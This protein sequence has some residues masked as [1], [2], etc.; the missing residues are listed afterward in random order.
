M[1]K[2]GPLRR[3]IKGCHQPRQ[4]S[5]T[6]IRWAPGNSQKAGLV[7]VSPASWSEGCDFFLRWDNLCLVGSV[8]ERT[9]KGTVGYWLRINLGCEGRLPTSSQ[10]T[11]DKIFKS[12]VSTRMAGPE[13]RGFKGP[14]NLCEMFSDCKPSLWNTFIH[15]VLGLVLV[16]QPFFTV[17][18]VLE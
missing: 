3:N 6:A 4:K 12:R 7:V 9:G 14:R 5:H 1:Y 8:S 18:F 11:W 16:H 10:S 2:I 15:T 17:S 13:D